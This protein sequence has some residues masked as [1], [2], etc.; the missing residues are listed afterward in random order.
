MMFEL[1]AIDDVAVPRDKFDPAPVSPSPAAAA[2][3]A[4]AASAK[5]DAKPYSIYN[6]PDR[7]GYMQI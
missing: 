4:A 6:Q 3:P 1:F 7:Y 2:T 5:S